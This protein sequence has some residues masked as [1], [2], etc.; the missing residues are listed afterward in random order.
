MRDFLV[1]NQPLAREIEGKLREIAGV[2]GRAPEKPA[3]VSTKEDKPNEKRHHKV[4][5]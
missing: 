1:T 4:G 3:P 2:P 5:V